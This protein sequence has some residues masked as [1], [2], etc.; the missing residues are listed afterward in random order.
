MQGGN[1]KFSLS[2]FF[3]NSSTVNAFIFNACILSIRFPIAL[4]IFYY[5]FTLFKPLKLSDTTTT[6]AFIPHLASL[7]S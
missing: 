3:S 2:F 4:Y 5:L 1:F 7:P 6:D